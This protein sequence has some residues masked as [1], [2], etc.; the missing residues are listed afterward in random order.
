MASVEVL[1]LVETEV[2]AASVVSVE[3]LD[4]LKQD[5]LQVDL[6]LVE[7]VDGTETEILAETV[8]FYEA[9]ETTSVDVVTDRQVLLEVIEA[10][11][12]QG[13]PGVVEDDV[14][15]AKRVDFV[16]DNLIYRGEA[17]V[18]SA[19]SAPVWRVRRITFGALDGDVTEQWAGGDA[20][21]DKIWA[22]RLSLTYV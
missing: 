15:Y 5:T 17:P 21:F 12:P 16:T 6:V 20:S 3:Q 19:E 1:K 11:G 7:H 22:D 10:A 9:L 8:A 2:V 13:P 14:M 18:G 4:V